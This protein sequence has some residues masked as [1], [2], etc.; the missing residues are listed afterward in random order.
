MIEVFAMRHKQICLA[1]FAFGTLSMAA[2]GADFAEL[3]KPPQ[4]Q[5]EL[6]LFDALF[7]G[8]T[9]DDA[10]SPL[11]LLLRQTE[12]GWLPAWGTARAFNLNV[13]QARVSD[14]TFT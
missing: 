12:D 14:V 7:G 3:C 10:S 8:E 2:G 13:H 4:Q 9:P 6:R 1:L 5:I 11:I